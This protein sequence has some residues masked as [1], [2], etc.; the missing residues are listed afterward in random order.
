M[1]QASYYFFASKFQYVDFTIPLMFVEE[2]SVD[3]DYR[4]MTVVAIVGWCQERPELYVTLVAAPKSPVD[5]RL[6]DSV[7]SPSRVQQYFRVRHW[8]SL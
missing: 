3:V 1:Q 5:S 4:L 8:I 7:D 6:D 2:S